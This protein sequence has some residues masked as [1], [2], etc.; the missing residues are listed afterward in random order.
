M[1]AVLDRD[2]VVQVEALRAELEKAQRMAAAASHRGD[3][4]AESATRQL[5]AAEE[6]TSELQRL[7]VSHV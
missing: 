2:L 4:E 3:S 5:A 1:C 6:L 7:Q